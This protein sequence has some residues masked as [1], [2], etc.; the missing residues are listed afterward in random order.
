MG[1]KYPV[2]SCMHASDRRMLIADAALKLI[3][4][5]GAR[6]LTHRAVDRAAGLP[7]GSTSYYCPRRSELLALVIGRYTELEYV[8]AKD[9]AA[10]L[11]R[12]MATN[13]LAEVLAAQ[14]WKWL[15]ARHALPLASRFEL[16]LAAGREPSLQSLVSNQRKKFLATI[17]GALARAGA[18]EPHSTAKA[19][20]ALIEGLMLDTLRA[21][22]P[23]LKREELRRIL[24]ALL[25][26]VPP[27]R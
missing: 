25:S 24:R 5:Q 16:F 21:G 23:V 20:L 19:I 27:E 2:R 13:D 14:M 8:E 7:P 3:G 26:D 12:P 11:D 9:Y 17:R 22:T 1:V 4:A 15:G 6:A 18:A 10:A